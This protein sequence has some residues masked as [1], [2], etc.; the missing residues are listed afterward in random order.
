VEKEI[1]EEKE[2]PDEDESEK[3]IQSKNVEEDLTE[4]SIERINCVKI[5]KIDEEHKEE[6]SKL[7]ILKQIKNK[8]MG[9][10]NK[11]I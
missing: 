1:L 6:E 11:T 5:V 3:V 4:H 8:I 2:T 10:C 7:N 9:K